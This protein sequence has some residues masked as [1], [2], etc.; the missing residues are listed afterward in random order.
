MTQHLSI[1]HLF[2]EDMKIKDN[3]VEF[4]VRFLNRN[5]MK[6]LLGIT[7]YEYIIQCIITQ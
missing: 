3:A 6:S 1:Q 5:A 2:E 7:N 4:V